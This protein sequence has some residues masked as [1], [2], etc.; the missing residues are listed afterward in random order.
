MHSHYH[1]QPNHGERADHIKVAELAGMPI[2]T[3]FQTEYRLTA[4]NC[5]VCRR[6]LRDALS[7]QLHIGP[8]C[9]SRYGYDD[10]PEITDTMRATA[11]GMVAAL[12]QT[13]VM[14]PLVSKYIVANRTN[15]RMM[16][17]ILVAW[18]SIHYNEKS[19]VLAV[20]PIIRALGYWR[21]AGKLEWDRSVVQLRI[22]KTT[23]ILEV[24]TPKNYTYTR[25]LK[26]T[27]P[28]AVKV[29]NDNGNFKA[30]Q[31]KASDQ[32]T[33]MALLSLHFAG[34]T[35][36][37]GEGVM[38]I[39]RGLPFPPHVETERQARRDRRM[40]RR[41]PQAQVKQVSNDHR[42]ERYRLSNGDWELRVF[43]P[44]NAGFVGDVRKVSRRRWISRDHYWA[45]RGTTGEF[46]RLA[47]LK[48][49]IF[50]HYNVHPLVESK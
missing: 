20:T 17:N 27:L 8:V 9:R 5:C 43:T 42:I 25:D 49:M 16:N 40:A 28:L 19:K 50:K 4:T 10:E 32:Q 45:F 22:D 23:G 41:H 7:V 11:M 15:G 44:Y 6:S 3:F 47:Q 2:P 29:F 39:P 24:Y 31:A 33:V 21:L 18:A 36:H 1:S 30:W 48:D 46:K 38:E 35:Y 12:E 14:D 34:K 37:D 13:G 26:E